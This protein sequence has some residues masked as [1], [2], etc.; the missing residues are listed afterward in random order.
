[1]S[2]KRFKAARRP[3]ETTH[4]TWLRLCMNRFCIC[5]N[6][7]TQDNTSDFKFAGTTKF[8]RIGAHCKQNPFKML[9]SLLV[10]K[11]HVN[12]WLEIVAS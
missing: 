11:D 9:T 6:V 5:Q 8:F 12:N 2:L 4:H 1:M 7:L 10:L 3:T